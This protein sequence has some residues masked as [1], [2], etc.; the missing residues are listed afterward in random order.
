MIRA[1]AR[2][3]SSDNT[4]HDSRRNKGKAVAG[5]EQDKPDIG[6]NFQYIDLAD[7]GDS[8]EGGSG[9]CNYRVTLLIHLYT[10][11]PIS[12]NM[13]QHSAYTIAIVGYDTDASSRLS[14]YQV[15]PTS[16]DLHASLL[17]M[18]LSRESLLDS[19]VLIILDW[20][21]PWTF[22]R[23]LRRWLEAVR[24]VMNDI[25]NDKAEASAAQESRRRKGKY[26]VDECRELRKR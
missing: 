1:L 22:L 3:D 14:V 24:K 21:K 26:V 5:P 12:V 9:H 18:A 8:R 19:L 11:F 6:I 25:E 15:P 23:E 16:N 4:R 13:F 2:S 7:D 10:D 17:P 20:E